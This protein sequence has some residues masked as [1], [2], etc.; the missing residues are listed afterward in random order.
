MPLETGGNREN[1]ENSSVFMS[2]VCSGRTCRETISKKKK[3]KKVD[4][5]AQ[6]HQQALDLLRRR[7]QLSVLLS[8]A[9][10]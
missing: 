9:L 8:G 1:L 10:L 6:S 3:K 5:C 4:P 7:S 2:F